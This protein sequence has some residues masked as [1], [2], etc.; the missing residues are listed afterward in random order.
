MQDYYEP[1]VGD[2]APDFTLHSTSGDAV[3]LKSFRGKHVVLFFYPKDDTPGCTAEACSFRDRNSDLTDEGAVVLGVSTD[4]IDILARG[5]WLPCRA[6]TFWIPRRLYQ[7]TQH[8]AAGLPHQ[9]L[10]ANYLLS[11][12]S[13][14]KRRSAR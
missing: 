4:S 14:L 3:T 12:V 10:P 8:P 7:R 5:E 9:C 1:K 13:L 2:M 6:A 11:T